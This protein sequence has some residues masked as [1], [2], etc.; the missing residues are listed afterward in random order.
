MTTTLYSIFYVAKRV[1]LN[2]KCHQS[3]IRLIFVSI[4]IF[5]PYLK[6]L[7]HFNRLFVIKNVLN[8]IMVEL[9]N[10]DT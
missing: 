4:V 10:F 8:D 5:N 9:V 6:Y 7:R 3:D 2:F 1:I